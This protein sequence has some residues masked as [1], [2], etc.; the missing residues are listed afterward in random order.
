MPEIETPPAGTQCRHAWHLYSLRLDLDRLGIDRA[1][2]I[3]RL[4]ARRI[5][6]SVHF[7][8]IPLHPY[9][10]SIARRPE[11]QCP[12]AMELYPRL[13]SLPLYPDL[14]DGQVDTI[15]GAVRDIVEDGRRKQFA[16]TGEIGRS[17]E[18]DGSH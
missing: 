5:G 15:I 7:I 2:F 18:G 16:G 13:V 14:T 11:N 4:N 1:E 6:A 9:F 10:E 3:R 17:R 8:P 12:I